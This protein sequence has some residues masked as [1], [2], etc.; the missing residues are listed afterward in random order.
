[1]AATVALIHRHLM[2]KVTPSYRMVRQIV[3][4]IQA[5]YILG[6]TRQQVGK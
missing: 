2:A 5:S 4:A 3:T 6:P 1:M